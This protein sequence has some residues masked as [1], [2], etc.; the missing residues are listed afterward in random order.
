[1]DLSAALPGGTFVE[2][3]ASVVWLG[4]GRGL[5]V[6]QRVYSASKNGNRKAEDAQLKA[7]TRYRQFRRAGLAVACGNRS[8]V[9]ARLM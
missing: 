7:P 6:Y 2:V 1:V 5:T 9:S 8:K 4:M 3:R